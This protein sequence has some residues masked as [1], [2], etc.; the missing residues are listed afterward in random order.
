[1]VRCFLHSFCLILFCF[2]WI[3]PFFPPD[4]A[5]DF[6]R[7]R[8]FVFLK[9][10]F[11]KFLC[12]EMV[13]VLIFF[14]GIFLLLFCYVLQLDFMFCG[15][16]FVAGFFFNNINE[17]LRVFFCCPKMCIFICG[18]DEVFG[19][20][21]KKK[22]FFYGLICNYWCLLYEI[23]VCC[24]SVR[25]MVTFLAQWMRQKFDLWLVLN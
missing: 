2:F 22:W 20:E 16:V 15:W 18:E 25:K 9:D 12:C 17:F 21:L 3:P 5:S 10:S 1:M 8:S 11:V 14:F 24:I 6:W 4:F 7:I 23:D 19:R 13:V